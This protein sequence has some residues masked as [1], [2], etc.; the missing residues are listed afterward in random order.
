MRTYMA[1]LNSRIGNEQ[2]KIADFVD[3]I[4]DLKSENENLTKETVT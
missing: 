4:N 1:S 2:R 3:E